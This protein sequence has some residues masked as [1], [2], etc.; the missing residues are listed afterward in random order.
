MSPHIFFVLFMAWRNLLWP[1]LCFLQSQKL[2]SHLAE[3]YVAT[4]GDVKRTILRIIEVGEAQLPLFQ[5][6]V[7]ALFW[8]RSWS[9]S[10]FYTCWTNFLN[11][12]IHSSAI[13]HSFIF[14]GSVI[15]FIII[16]FFY[17]ILTFSF[18][19][20]WMKWIRI[21]IGRLGMRIRN[22]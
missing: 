10:K 8:W 2:L 16:N 5:C 12:F 19:Y 15:C 20:V 3:V 1:Y 18:T 21:R 6:C 11:T 17:S 22:W 4:S 13:L 9:Y 7:T 14:L